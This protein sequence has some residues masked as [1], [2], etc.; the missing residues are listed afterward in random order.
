MKTVDMHMFTRVYRR[1]MLRD[2]LTVSHRTVHVHMASGSRTSG[3]GRLILGAQ[4]PHGLVLPSQLVMREQSQLMVRGEFTIYSG[5]TIF[6]NERA[7]LVLGSGYINNG[8]N[9]SCFQ[10]IEIGNNVAISE[11]VTLR[12]SDNHRLNGGEP[13][14]PIRIGDNVWI[15][16]G[17]IILKGV[18]IG[19]GA[20]IA[21][22]SVVNRDVPP[23][24][25]VAG[26]PA[27]VRKTDVEWS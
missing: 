7:T 27:T 25:L 2:I 6:V 23:R 3:P 14:K 24:S 16:L 10:R 26:V 5:H 15:G 12:D 9:L 20:V 21:A 11:D 17:A 1:W 4:W 18:S 13:T 19:D 22:G 8:L